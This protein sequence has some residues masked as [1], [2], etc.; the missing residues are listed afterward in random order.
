M[1]K[2]RSESRNNRIIS[3]AQTA[4]M[5]ALCFVGFKFMQIPIPVPG[6]S[7]VA[8]H[9]GNVF[10]VLAALLLGGWNGGLAGAVGMTL[11]DLLDPRYITAA[12]KTFILKLGIGLICGFVAHSIGHISGD[13]TEGQDSGRKSIVLW[14]ALGCSAGLGFNVIFEPVVSYLYKRFLLGQPADA[15]MI[16]AKWQAGATLINAVIAIVVAT[17]LYVAVRPALIRAG[18]FKKDIRL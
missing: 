7:T 8:I 5:A 14:S 2:N 16:L 17:L 6:D 9:L 4:L 11:A 1:K 12:P 3:L 13:N 18:I 10:C 15:A